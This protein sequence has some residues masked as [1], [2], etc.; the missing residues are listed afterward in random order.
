MV[1]EMLVMVLRGSS[2]APANATAPA[3]PGP[4]GEGSGRGGGGNG[5]RVGRGG[6]GRLGR[7]G[8]HGLCGLTGGL[9]C[10]RA[11]HAGAVLVG[12]C[13]DSEGERGEREARGKGEEENEWLLLH[14]HQQQ[15]QAGFLHTLL[16]KN[17]VKGCMSR[18]FNHATFDHGFFASRVHGSCTTHL[19]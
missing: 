11:H 14:R 3:A 7:V 17:L 10:G 2:A 1:V 9:V 8:L 12:C 13:V 5:G 16:A 6:V 18:G 19:V 15:K 4:R